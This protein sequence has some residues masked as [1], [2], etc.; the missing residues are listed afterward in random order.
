MAAG[1]R[2][3]Q[4]RHPD[5]L[6][7]DTCGKSSKGREILLCRV[8]DGLVPDADK[9]VVLLTTTHVATER[10]S[11]SGSLRLI[12]WLISDDP[13]AAEIRR[14]QIVLVMP[15]NDPDGHAGDGRSE[16]YM[17]WSLD[18]VVEPEKHPEAVVLQKVI[19]QHRPDVHVDV[20]GVWFAEQTMWESTGIA[21]AGGLARSYIAEIPRLMDQAA[22]EAGFLITAGEESAGQV[23]VS[24]PVPGGNHHFYIRN[25]NVNDCV[26]SY[27]QYHSIAFTIEAGFEESTAIRL[28]RLLEIG[29]AVWRGE[30]YAGY[31]V[32]QVGCWTSMAIAAWGTTATERRASRVELWQK[33]DQLAYGCAHPEPRGTMMAFLFTD[34]ALARRVTT[35]KD[36]TSVVAKLEAKATKPSDNESNAENRIPALDAEAIAKFAQTTPA[37]NAAL[38]GPMAEKGR[39]AI[40][41]GVV[42]RLLIPYADAKLTHLRLDGHEIAESDTD[43]YHVRRQPGTIVEVAIPPGKVGPVHVVTCAYDTQTKRRAGFLSTDW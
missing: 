37:L 40:A 21:W 31:P 22:E 23:R 39:G 20:H 36:L 6:R 2:G 35:K 17:C 24:A 8:T 29:N 34:P 27:H 3:W 12:K 18:G 30:R 26:Y 19:D 10:N 5:A 9:Q 7:V 11:C 15:C 1:L 25:A 32:N 16:I 33:L 28:R 4:E 38:T 42:I 14:R 13:A 41:H 43:G